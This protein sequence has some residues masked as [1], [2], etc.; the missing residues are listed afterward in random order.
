MCQYHR[1]AA[2]KPFA[3]CFHRNRNGAATGLTQTL[4]SARAH[5]SAL[6]W[7]LAGPPMSSVGRSITK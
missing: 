3:M 1:S 6:R 4:S 7:I 2:G 5:C